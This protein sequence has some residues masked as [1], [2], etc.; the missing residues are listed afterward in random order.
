MIVS[1]IDGFVSMSMFSRGEKVSGDGLHV[2]AQEVDMEAVL[3]V[4]LDERDQSGIP[5]RAFAKAVP[6]AQMV[7]VLVDLWEAEG[8]YDTL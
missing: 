5:K 8:L 3:D 2:K 6:L 4:L 7:D 1:S